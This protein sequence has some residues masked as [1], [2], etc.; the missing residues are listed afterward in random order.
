MDS[1]NFPRSQH[2]WYNC[3]VSAA[4]RELLSVI[5][6]VHNEEI[7]VPIFLDRLMS[8]YNQFRDK[9]RLEILF[10]NNASTDDTLQR[11]QT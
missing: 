5:V 8:V 4:N 11:I 1:M 10:I 7:N 6:P 9:Y 3:F 2:F